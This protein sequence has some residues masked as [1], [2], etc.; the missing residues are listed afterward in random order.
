MN[1]WIEHR[2]PGNLIGMAEDLDNIYSES[3]DGRYGP[4][5]RESDDVYVIESLSLPEPISDEDVELALYHLDE[6]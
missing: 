3:D 4:M 6:G 5:L 1:F 2:Y